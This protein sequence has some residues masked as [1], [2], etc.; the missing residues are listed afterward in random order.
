MHFVRFIMQSR[1]IQFFF[2]NCSNFF[3][4]LV[5]NLFFLASRISNTYTFVLGNKGWLSSL[6]L[7]ETSHRE[8]KYQKISPQRGPT[9]SG[10]MRGQKK[11]VF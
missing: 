1:Q 2:P 7:E 6:V 3:Y 4:N 11:K 10:H 5:I 8:S 9:R